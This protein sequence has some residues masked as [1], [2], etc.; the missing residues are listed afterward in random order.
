MCAGDADRS[1]SVHLRYQ[2]ERGDMVEEW[3]DAGIQ[4]Q[5]EKYNRNGVRY[6]VRQI[7]VQEYDKGEKK[8]CRR[9]R[10][11][12]QEVTGEIRLEFYRRDAH[13]YLEQIPLAPLSMS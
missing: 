13:G 7:S 1:Y 8:L 12:R 9:I 3:L 11:I 4:V 6:V 2:P 5:T 10:E